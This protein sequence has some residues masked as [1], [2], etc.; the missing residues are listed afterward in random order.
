MTQNSAAGQNL[1]Q[2]QPHGLKFSPKMELQIKIWSKKKAISNKFLRARD[3][4][5]CFSLQ[6]VEQGMQRMQWM[7]PEPPMLMGFNFIALELFLHV[8]DLKSQISLA[9]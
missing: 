3:V 8:K 1:E 5:G 6:N 4:K 9:V 2:K 7:R